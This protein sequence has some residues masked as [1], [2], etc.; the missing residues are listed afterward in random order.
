MSDAPTAQSKVSSFFACMREYQKAGQRQGQAAY[1]A[2]YQV[3][4]YEAN[5]ITGTD[6]DPFYDDK[7]VPAFMCHI[8]QFFEETETG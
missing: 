4:P 6:L 1:N 7:R 3:W 2:F 5:Q 8:N